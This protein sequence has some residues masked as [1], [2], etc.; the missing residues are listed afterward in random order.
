[1]TALMISADSHVIEPRDLYESLRG[2]WGDRVPTVRR[3]D[4]GTD[5]WWVD[6]QRTNSFAG[7]SQAGARFDDAESLLLADAIDNVREQVW[8]PDRYV[9]DNRDDG[10]GASVLYPTQQMQHYAV[11][12][13]PLLTATCRVY[14]DWLA[15]FCAAHPDRLRGIALLNS[16]DADAAAAELARAAGRGLAGAML[17]VGLPHRQ[18]Y[19][20][21][22]FDRVWAAAVEHGIAV[23]FHIGTYRADPTRDKVV[24]IAG[25]QTDT[26]RPVQ[27]AFATA[28]L[29]VRS[30]LADLVFSGVLERHPALRVVSAEH[31]VGWLAHFVE[32]MDYTYTQRATRG[33][34]FADGALPSD[35]VRRQVAVQFCE[36]PLASAVIDAVGALNLMW[37]CDYPHSEGTF[38]R[39]RATVDRL[40][41]SQP[42]TVRRAVLVDNAATL[43]RIDPAVL[44][45]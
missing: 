7:G 33:L 8:S 18:T 11:R 38:P 22:R 40:L 17:P 28:D 15:E 37:G 4:D 1:M 24:V 32:R 16:D 42:G 26:P 23:S 36:D 5:W 27:T 44:A 41:A 19:A 12:N 10:V 3:A 25:A 9:A 30:T 2:E 45:A 21:R 6:A 14:N 13:T 39:S 34:R 31:E 35:F 43:Y 29:Y 20:D